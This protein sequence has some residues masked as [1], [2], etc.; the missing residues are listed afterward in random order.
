MHELSLASEI[1][2]MVEASAAREHFRQ[3]GTLRL[4]AGALAGVEV[5]ALRFALEAMVAGTCLEGAV[6][7]IDEPPG[8]A[9]CSQCAAEVTVGSRADLCPRCN[10]YPLKVISG[11]AL[12]VVDL[13]VVDE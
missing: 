3:V 8:R 4:E 9:L 10:G 1:V 11:G 12:R 13:L 5:S 6:I 7:E 2:R